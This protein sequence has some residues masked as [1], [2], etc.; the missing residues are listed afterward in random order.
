MRI[1]ITCPIKN[2]LFSTDDYFLH[3]GLSIVTDK[4]GEKK[5]VGMVGLNSPCPF[6][7]EKHNVNVEELSCGVRDTS[8]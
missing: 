2:K 3:K 6:C 8:E 4:R 1:Y 5:L 7:G